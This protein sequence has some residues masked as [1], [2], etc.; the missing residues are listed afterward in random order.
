MP[1]NTGW[2]ASLAASHLRRLFQVAVEDANLRPAFLVGFDKLQ[3]PLGNLVGIVGRAVA[4]DA[5]E[6]DVEVLIDRSIQ[7]FVSS[8]DI[9]T[10]QAVVVVQILLALSQ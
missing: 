7:F 1:S 4:E 10:L 2:I 3:V 6:R 9:K 8:P 5:M